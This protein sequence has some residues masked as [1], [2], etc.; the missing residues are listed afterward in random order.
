MQ[1]AS[2]T[3][4]V[5]YTALYKFFFDLIWF[6]SRP[7]RHRCDC[8]PT[9]L[10]LTSILVIQYMYLSRTPAPQ[11]IT[12]WHLA[13]T[14]SYPGMALREKLAWQW[15]C[16]KCHFLVT[17]TPLDIKLVD[18]LYMVCT[19]LRA[20]FRHR[21]TRRF[22]GDKHQTKQ[23]NSQI[24]SMIIDLIN[25]YD[26]PHRPIVEGLYTVESYWKWKICSEGMKLRVGDSA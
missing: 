16:Y 13:K 8:W 11:D 18:V 9:R 2:L 17:T 15:T 3:E 19:R 5:E 21:T 26:T 10:P 22:G 25:T 14:K 20:K 23:T 12:S 6:A 7:T 24:F 1:P 4:S